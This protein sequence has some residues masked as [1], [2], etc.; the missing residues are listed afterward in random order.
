MWTKIRS[1][2]YGRG[3]QNGQGFLATVVF[4]VLFFLL[5]CLLLLLL[6][7]DFLFPFLVAHLELD[8]GVV[9]G[10]RERQSKHRSSGQGYELLL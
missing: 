7:P 3:T 5:G 6:K 1:R 2:W 8:R 10:R 9:E 4:F